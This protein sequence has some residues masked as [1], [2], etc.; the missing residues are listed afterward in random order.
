[1]DHLRPQGSWEEELSSL[2]GI[3]VS[4]FQHLHPTQFRVAQ[5]AGQTVATTECSRGCLSSLNILA[6]SQARTSPRQSLTTIP[7]EKHDFL[8]VRKAPRTEVTCPA[9]SKRQSQ[10]PDPSLLG[11]S[12][13]LTRPEV[14][15]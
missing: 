15:P 5:G 3:E 2:A 7:Q 13:L 12:L 11:S 6:S 1:M 9:A 14:D 4:G 10:D 8:H